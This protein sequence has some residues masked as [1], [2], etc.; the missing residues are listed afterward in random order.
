MCRKVH[1]NPASPVSGRVFFRGVILRIPKFQTGLYLNE[2][3]FVRIGE[4]QRNLVVLPGLGDALQDVRVGAWRSA[5]FYRNLGR[6]HTV[7]LISRRRGLPAGCSIREMAADYA[8]VIEECIGPADVMGISMGGYIA[9]DLAVEFPGCV[10]RL[11]LAASA[12]RPGPNG[13]ALGR[14]WVAWAQEG[15]WPNICRELAG[16]T[17]NGFRRPLY[18]FLIPIWVGVL[19]RRPADPSDFIVSVEACLGHDAGDRLP[20]M[21]VPTLVIGG[22]KDGFF[23]ESLIRETAGRIPNARLHL[24]EGAGHGVFIEQKRAFDKFVKEFIEE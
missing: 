10:H 12:R 14:R 15:R 11:I 3:P 24:I 17:F 9:Q 4:R 1:P 16:L 20:A 2:F 21:Q 6:E 7:Y 5:W 13:P 22:T 23:P 18:D 8:R 19:R